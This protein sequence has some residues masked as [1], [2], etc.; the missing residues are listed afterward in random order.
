MPEST[1][2]KPDFSEV[3]LRVGRKGAAELVTKH[4][5][6][7]SARSVADW[8]LRW[9]HVNGY[10]L[11]E[12]AELFAVAQAKVDAALSSRDGKAPAPAPDAEAACRH[13]AASARP[14]ALDCPV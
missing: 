2:S 9:L 12:T 6:P 1:R 4:F 14:P 3:P 13:G 5:F 7:V 10:A 8:P 11:C